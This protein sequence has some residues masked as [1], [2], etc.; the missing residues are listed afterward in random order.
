MPTAPSTATCSVRKPA[1]IWVD[2]VGGRASLRR[3]D[4]SHFVSPRLIRTDGPTATVALVASCAALLAGD[5]VELEV[6]VGEG[7]CLELIEPSGTVAYNA[8]GRRSAWR[9][10]VRVDAGGRLVW[11]G[12]PFVVA[13]GAD[14]RRDLR[15]ALAA[16]AVAATREV[17]VLGRGGERHGG[18]LRSR[19]Y[20]E[21]ASRPLLVEDLDL[22][23]PDHTRSPALLGANRV[24]ATALLLGARPVEGRAS[25]Y[26]TLLAG[27]GA[28]ARTLA[29]E[30]HEAVGELE[31]VWQ[32]WRGHALDGGPVAGS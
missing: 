3:L 14:V 13:D 9:A 8:R 21:H 28:W 26:E 19:T 18:A 23:D 24:I 16:G 1:R 31:P 29:Q 4:Y 10:D 12:A 5:E 32:R 17:L 25:P 2:L 15:I 30:A 7:A 27:S 20:A 11:M 6:N 22:H